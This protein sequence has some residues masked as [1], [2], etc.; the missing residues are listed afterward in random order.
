MAASREEVG[1]EVCLRQVQHLREEDT[2]RALSG[3]DGRTAG[4]GGRAGRLGE[5]GAVQFPAHGRGQ[6]FE[7]HVDER[8]HVVGQQPR[9]MS[10]QS[11][12]VRS[13]RHGHHVGD[14][15]VASDGDRRA[16]HIVV[17]HQRGLDLGRLDAE[18]A[19]LELVVGPAEVLELPVRPPPGEVTGPVHAS[20]GRAERV[21]Q[22]P[23]LGQLGA[24]VV[25]ADRCPGQ[26]QLPTAPGGSGRRPASST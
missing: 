15:P 6:P 17:P 12:R 9:H 20:T 19:D 7:G 24:S 5:R 21:G 10:A 25:A 1:V 14:E 11:G 22:E 3:R 23:F 18:P 4:G 26:V 2:Q 16:R 13:P 8:H